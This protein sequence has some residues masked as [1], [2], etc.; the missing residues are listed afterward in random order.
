MGCGCFLFFISLGILAIL[1]IFLEK[2]KKWGKEVEKEK[3]IKF[4]KAA[5]KGD[6]KAVEL[7]LESGRVAVN[8]KDEYGW[9]ALM[10]A[11]RNGHKEVVKL[12]LKKGADVNAKNKGGW[13]ALM[14]A[15]LYGHKEIV[16]ILKSYGA[17]E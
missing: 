10:L 14:L 2:L 17:K 1:E 4:F 16:E 9:T 3:Q 8:V 11:S 7:L 15:T 12:L 5:E 6:E 13:T